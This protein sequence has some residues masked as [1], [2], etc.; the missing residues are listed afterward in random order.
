MEQ[1]T[2]GEALQVFG[3]PPS[4][5]MPLAYDVDEASRCLLSF[6]YDVCAQ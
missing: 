1:A 2:V 6:R 3:H 5:D 4:P